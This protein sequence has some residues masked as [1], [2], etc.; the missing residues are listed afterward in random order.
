[1]LW[2][3]FIW[4]QWESEYLLGPCPDIQPNRAVDGMFDSIEVAITKTL[5]IQ[6]EE[7]TKEKKNTL[8]IVVTQVRR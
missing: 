1:M 3:F 4:F 8:Y 5:R 2:G 6:K 7:G